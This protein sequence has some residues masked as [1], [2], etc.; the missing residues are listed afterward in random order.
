MA[1]VCHCVGVRDRAIVKAVHHGCCDLAAVQAATGAATQCQGCVPLVVDIIAANLP[2]PA[3]PA[4][5]A[6][7]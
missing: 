6:T 3:L 7:A 5:L 1:I 4:A 2:S